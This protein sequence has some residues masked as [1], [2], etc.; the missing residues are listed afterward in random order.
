MK[1]S[2]ALSQA[3][4]LSWTMLFSLMLPLLGGVWLDKQFDTVPL[5][6]LV[7]TVLGILAATLGVARQAIRIFSAAARTSPSI[8]AEETGEEE[9]E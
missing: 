6:I 3:W 2:T 8:N 7:G 4:S 1:K 5:F 9:P